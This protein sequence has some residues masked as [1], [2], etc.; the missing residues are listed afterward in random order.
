MN[1]FN[2]VVTFKIGS[3]LESKVFYSKDIAWGLYKDLCDEG[4]ECDIYEM[5]C[6]SL[7]EN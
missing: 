1:D 4:H 5:N 2:Y 6:I 7:K 3:D